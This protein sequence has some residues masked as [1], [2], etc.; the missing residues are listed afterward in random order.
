MN[1]RYNRLVSE[2]R[3]ARELAL[4]LNMDADPL[5]HHS[6]PQVFE[7][8][9]DVA[10]SEY[11]PYADATAQ[12]EL[13]AQY[14]GR[15][16]D[17][18]TALC[19]LRTRFCVLLL[20]RDQ[21]YPEP[22]KAALNQERRLHLLHREEDREQWIRWLKKHNEYVQY[23]LTGGAQNVPGRIDIALLRQLADR[24]D[25][26]LVRINALDKSELI[27]NRESL[28]AHEELYSLP[29]RRD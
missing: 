6:E 24:I 12:Y 1:A 27:T 25:A 11:E 23:E 22:V 2:Y 29:Y 19:E 18:E 7:S 20:Q 14:R 10:P 4:A 28:N 15:V 8:R 9:T 21:S 3:V 16:K 5:H 13:E 17:L 26:E